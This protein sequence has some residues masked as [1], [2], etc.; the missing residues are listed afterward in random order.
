M[1]VVCA[2]LLAVLGG[3][4]SPKA[5]DIK[6]I[7]SAVGAEAEDDKISQLLKELEGKDI[8]EVI[9]AGT[10]KLAS[11]PSGGGGGAAAPAAGGA[12]AGGAAA[13]APE[14]EPEEE[15]EEDMGFDLFD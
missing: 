14:P 9:A 2:F 5:A 6:K 15:E 12:A 8:A 13:A 11:V 10:E 4:A 1:K 7:L 3:N